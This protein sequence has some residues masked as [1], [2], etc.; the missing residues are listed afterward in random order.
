MNISV[1]SE[2][3]VIPSSSESGMKVL[4]RNLF[5]FFINKSGYSGF[6]LQ[7]F[8]I[9]WNI[10]PY[11]VN[12]SEKRQKPNHFTQT[13]ARV[14]LSI[15]WFSYQ[16][17]VRVTNYSFF[18]S[19]YNIENFKRGKT[20]ENLSMSNWNI[21]SLTSLLDECGLFWKTDTFLK[22]RLRGCPCRSS[23]CFLFFSLRK[24]LRDC[25]NCN[26]LKRVSRL[27]RLFVRK[28]FVGAPSGHRQLEVCDGSVLSFNRRQ[29]IYFW[30]CSV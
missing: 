20:A 7:R 18:P 8:V 26:A 10:S 16:I 13:C 15:V 17:S 6:V 3:S 14:L 4:N 2:T 22:K 5:I 23:I 11:F 21:S 19:E 28:A 25:P 27:S 9:G 29:R 1:D 24:T 30:I 12:Q